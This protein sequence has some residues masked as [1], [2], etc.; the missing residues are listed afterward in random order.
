MSQLTD[1]A[2][3]AAM[4]AAE[5]DDAEACLEA[6]HATGGDECH[7]WTPPPSWVVDCP[8]PSW[9]GDLLA[10]RADAIE[11]VDLIAMRLLKDDR[12][13][14]LKL[15]FTLRERVNAFVEAYR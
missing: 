9:E 10:L 13:G 7:Q 11:A 1:A 12:V 6:A 5:E 15:A 8:P 3:L 14:A 2:A 4:R